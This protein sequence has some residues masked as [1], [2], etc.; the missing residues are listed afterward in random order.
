MKKR[1]AIILIAVAVILSIAALVYF[2]R[3]K[4]LTAEDLANA[5]AKPEDGTNQT[6]PFKPAPGKTRAARNNN[7]FNLKLTGAAWK[8]KVPKEFNTDGKFEQFYSLEFGIR[9]G[10]KNMINKVNRS[11]L[12]TLYRLLPVLTPAFENNT[13][14]YISDVTKLTGIQP[15]APLQMDRKTATALGAA[16]ARLEGMELSPQE[17]DRGFDLL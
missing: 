15:N 5:A 1:T 13:E 4:K 12:D 17:I 7:P 6:G 16:I 8:G 14:K 3:T 10:L 2:L 9:A 11:G